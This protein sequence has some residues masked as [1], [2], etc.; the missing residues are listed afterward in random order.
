[1]TQLY[2]FRAPRQLVFKLADNATS[3]DPLNAFLE[4]RGWSLARVKELQRS[5]SEKLTVDMFTFTTT[6]LSAIERSLQRD[7]DTFLERVGIERRNNAN[8]AED[9]G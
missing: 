5:I 3:D 1:M 4:R 7:V 6:E 8:T 9:N 2:L